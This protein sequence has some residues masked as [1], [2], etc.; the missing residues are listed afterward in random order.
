MVVRKDLS[1]SQ[2]LVQATHAAL[3][4]T[5]SFSLTNWDDHPH[6]VVCGVDSLQQLLSCS[7]HLERHKVLHK[8]WSEPDLGDEPTALATDLLS[9]EARRFLRKYRLLS[10]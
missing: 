8:V 6:L 2:Q 3:E 5:K 4:A 10:L 9:G 7:S 1:P